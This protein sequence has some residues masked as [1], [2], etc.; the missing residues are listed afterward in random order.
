MASA[1]ETAAAGQI[2]E[3]FHG[4]CGFEIAVVVGEAHNFIGVADV[5]PL[6]VGTKRIKGDAE[7]L[8]EVGGKDRDLLRFAIGI[9]AAEDLDF[10]GG[11]FSEEE[12]AVG[13]EADEARVIE[14]GGVELDL[15][16]FG[17]DGPRIRGSGNDVGAVVDGLIGHGL[18]QVGECKMAARS[19]RFVSR[20]SECGLTGEDGVFGGGVSGGVGSRRDA[21]SGS[22]DGKAENGRSGEETGRMIHETSLGDELREVRIDLENPTTILTD[23]GEGTGGA[24]EAGDQ[25]AGTGD[26]GT[27]DEGTR[28]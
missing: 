3:V 5:N 9:D 22:E 6:R 12:I 17:R 20:V 18:G 28:D 4:A 7:R 1:A 23:A 19:G 2:G 16:T 25:G 8:M 13:G 24:I 14:I 11:A 15:K 10:A 27:R 26:E 21:K